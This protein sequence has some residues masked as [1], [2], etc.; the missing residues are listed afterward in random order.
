MTH[1]ISVEKVKLGYN[2]VAVLENLS[3]HIDEQ[4]FI[5]IVGPNGSGKT[6]LVQGILGLIPLMSGKITFNNT[7]QK[8]IG[9]M[10]QETTVDPHFPA[11]VLEVVLSGSLNESRNFYNQDTKKRA[12]DTLSLLGIK[13]LKN[14]SFSELSGGQRQKILL[15]RAIMATKKLLILDE[16]SNNLDQKSKQ[17]LYELIKKLQKDQKIAIVMVTH[18]LDHGNLIGDKILSLRPQD[19]FFGPTEDFIRKVHHE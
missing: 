18:D 11:S 9:Y 8:H 6:T 7:S 19:Y 12:I 15:A 16:P 13:S 3:F 14:R 5:C 2:R 17:N 1:L 10:P 4:D